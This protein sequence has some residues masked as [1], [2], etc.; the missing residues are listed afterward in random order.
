[1]AFTADGWDRQPQKLIAIHKDPVFLQNAATCCRRHI[2]E[3]RTAGLKL[4]A[5]RRLPTPEAHSPLIAM[6]LPPWPR[7]ELRRFQIGA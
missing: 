5:L 6:R 2:P 4:A 7:A 1:M 3:S